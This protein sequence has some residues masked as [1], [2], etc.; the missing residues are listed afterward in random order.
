MGQTKQRWKPEERRE[1]ILE[2]AMRLFAEKGF[3]RTTVDDIAE[4]CGI[5]PGLVYHYFDSKTAILQALID[6][7]SFLPM[8]QE[9]LSKPPRPTIEATLTELAEAFWKM[10]ESKRAF[11]LMLHGEMHHN[12]EVSRLVGE[13]SKMGA[14]MVADYLREQQKAGVLVQWV[15]PEV[16]T[17][18]LFAALFECFVAH[19]L[20]SPYLR[21]IAPKRL[22][23][24]IVHL[25]LHGALKSQTNEVPG[26]GKGT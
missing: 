13:M 7:H 6:R 14:K 17:R 25:F 1:Q 10:L 20:L 18:A 5:A 23:S 2:A 4:A 22:I 21:R 3:D 11:A 16:F 15:D 9:V 19:H 12:P 26:G 24:G 8:M